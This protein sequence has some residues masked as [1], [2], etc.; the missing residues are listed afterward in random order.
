MNQENKVVKI[1]DVI[2][3]QIPEFIVSENPNFPEF[4][5]QYYI[6]QEFQGGTIDL[7][8]NLVAYRNV[9]AFDNTNLNSDTF[10]IE[11]VSVFDDEIFVDS[12]AG[13][14]KQYGLIKIDDEIIT[15][16][17]IT[18]NSFIGCIRGFSGI[19]SLSQENNQEY[20]TFSTTSA[21]DHTTNSQVFNLSSLFLNEFFKKIKYQFTPGFEE[22]SFDEN[23]NVPNFVSKA[24][25]FYRSK[26][27]D[28]SYKILFKVL[29]NEDVQIVKPY[30]FTFTPSDDKWIVCETFVCEAI[31]GDPTKL[32]GQTLY[33]DENASKKILPASGSIYSISRFN[34]NNKTYYKINIFA[35]YSNN[36]NP[37]GS[38]FGTFAETPRTY[39][40]ENVPVNSTVITVDSTVGFEQSG[41]LVIGDI[42]IEYTDKT[43]TQFL[44][45]T[46]VSSEI[47][48]K[49]EI[50]ASNYVYSYEDGDLQTK[51]LLRIVNVLS[52]ID[53][54]DNLYALKDDPI[55]LE[56]LG[57]VE[58]TPFKD[59][60]IYNLPLTVY[61]G[62]AVT[63]LPS[64]L[65]E[66]FDLST[67]LVKT[68]YS[69]YLKSG[70]YV[71]LYRTIFNEKIKS[72]IAISV[73]GEKT[74]TI[75]PDSP[76][77]GISTY[78]GSKITAK[79][80]LFKS[81]STTFP[82]IND[83][84]LANIQ[85]SYS[86]DSYNYITSNGFPNFNINP[87]KRES[88]LAVN[89]TDYSTLDGDHNFYD[90]DLV[91]IQDYTTVGN[92]SNAIGIN[93]GISLFVKKISDSSIKLSYSA[94]NVGL[95]SYINFLELTNPPVDISISG[96]VTS[97]NLID[98][99]LYDNNLT[100][101]K[102]FKK[103]P[104]V[105]SYPQ[106][107]IET[108]PG[109]IGI[110]CNG[111]EIQN[112]KSYDRIFY[113]RIDS[114]NVLNSGQNYDLN[115]PPR[116]EINSQTGTLNT[117]LSP[118]MTGK[119]N[120]IVVLYS[121]FDYKNTPIVTVSGGGV[122]AEVK[123]EVKMK[124][125]SKEL[126]F[127]ASST[128]GFVDDAEDLFKFS[129]KHGLITGDKII[130]QTLGGKEIG[131]GNVATDVLINDSIYYVINVGAGT[132]FR[133]ASTIE[134]A[135]SNQYITIREFGKGT[136][137]FVSV[138]KKRCI[139]SVTV[140]DT[141]VTFKYK[142]IFASASG[143]NVYDNIITIQNH[144]FLNND[145]IVYSYLG[146]PLSGLI[147]NDIYYYVE[148]V[149]ENKFKLKQSKTSTSTIDISNSI[150]DST[151]FFRYSPIRVEISGSLSTD[152]QNN[153]LGIPA[154]L[155]PIVTG[156]IDSILVAKDE[157]SAVN[158]Y[159]YPSIFNYENSPKIK[160]LVGS[161]ANL[162]PLVVDG[163][164]VKVI[165]KNSGTNYF[166]T[167]ELQ[168]DGTGYGAKL[169]P[170]IVD[171]EI[172][173]V[174]IVNPGV[175][176][177]S[178]AKIKVVPLGKN[179]KISANI[180]S[181]QINEVEK[182]K[183]SNLS[184]GA[185]LG[186]KYSEFGNIFGIFYLSSDLSSLFEIPSL[187]PTQNPTVHSRII[188]W[189]YDGSPI[190]GPDGYR[191]TDGTGGVRRM[192][193]S[194][195]L[196]TILAN[197]RPPSYDAKF[198][199]DDYEYVEGLGDLDEYNGR[200]CITPEFPKGVYAYFCTM[201]KNRTPIFPYFIG[202]NY[203]FVP[204]SSNFD[205]KINQDLD[206]NSLNISKYTLPYGIENKENYYEY[207]EFNQKYPDGEIIVTN[208]SRGRVDSI[209]I[210][211]GGSDY[212]IGSN[213]IFDETDTG[214]SGA[215]AQ[216]LELSGV[217]ISSINSNSQIISNV[218]F[219][220]KDGSVIGICT[221][222]H[223]ITNGDYVNITGISTEKFNSLEGFVQI[224]VPSVSSKL[225]QNVQ[226]QS[227]TGIVTSI[228]IKDPISKFE[229]DS[230]IEIDSETMQVIG[231]DYKNNC[232]NVLREIG[233]SSH[234]P[235]SNVNVLQKNIKIR[236]N[237]VELPDSDEVYY[238]NPSASVS[239]GISTEV[240]VGNT[241]T[242]Y[243]FGY[244]VSQK[245]FLRHG[246]IFLPNHKFVTGD[247]LT[248]IPDSISIEVS[249]VGNLDEIDNLY[250][251][252]LDNDSIGLTSI[253][254]Q[255]NST[256]NLLL[257]T[258]AENSF[259][260]KFKTN[261]SIVTGNI[262][263]NQTVV[264]TAS[265]HGL[266]VGDKVYLNVKSGITTTFAVT[267]DD[268]TAKLK[269]N[270]NNNPLVNVYENDT[271]VFDLSSGT[272]SDTTFK[273]YL[274]KN[275]QIEYFGNKENGLEVTR[276]NNSLTL[277][278]SEYT[279]KIL[280]YNIDTSTK[281]VFSDQ[282]VDRFN[283]ILINSSSYNNTVCKIIDS[284][285]N[286][287]TINY[288]EYPERLSYTSEDSEL[289]YNIVSSNTT[290]PISK[291]KLL[292]K[293]NNYKKL[294]QIKYI[295]G[296]GKN[297]NLLPSSTTIGKI[298][299]HKVVNNEFIL[300]TDRT[301]KPFSNS[302]S[303]VFLS[304]NY[305]V[306]NVEIISRGSN[307]LSSP[308][309]NLYS[310]SSDTLISDF[311]AFVTIKNGSIDEFIISNPGKG[312][313]S[314]D[315]QIIFTENNNG[316]NILDVSYNPTNS[317]VTLTL[318][319]PVLGFT[320]SNPLPFEVGD[321]IFVDNIVYL[322]NGY[323]SKD[324]S[325]KFFDVVG[326]LTAF[327]SQDASQIM[328]EIDVDPGTYIPSSSLAKGAYVVNSKDIPEIKVNLTE[329]IFYSDEPVDGSK[330]I[331]NTNND[332]LTK[333]IKIQ[334]PNT[335]EVNDVIVGDYSRS[336]GTVIKVENYNT[337]LKT[338][339]SVTQEIGWTS[340]QGK[341]STIVQKLPDNDYY[342]RFSYSLKSNQQISNWYS[343]ISDLSH[344]SG[345]KK[346]ADLILE[347]ESVGVSTIKSE[348]SSQINISLQSYGDI[349]TVNDFDLVKENVEDYDLYASDIIAFDSKILTD[350]L[351]SKNNR[352]LSIDDISNL[353][354]TDIPK[355]VTIPIDEVN[356]VTALKYIFFVQSSS[357]FLG[358]FI[359]P[360]FFE[361]SAVRNNSTIY[362]SSYANNGIFN[363][364]NVVASV[365]DNDT[366]IIN[367]VPD[368]PF[369]TFLIRA[370]RE[371]SS[372]T[373]GVT[374][375][376][377]G[378]T[379][380]VAITTSY[381]S[382]V[383]PTEKTIYSIPLT[384]SS[385]GTLFVGISSYSSNIESFYELSFLHNNG[386]IETNLYNLNDISG[387]GTVG[388]STSSGDLII[389]YQGVSGVGVTIHGNFNF[390]VETAAP[391]S[392]ISDSL[393]RLNSSEINFSGSSQVA[394]SSISSEYGA[395]KYVIEVTKTTSG[396]NT[397]KSLIA[398]DSIH[399]K[400]GDYLNHIYY[401]ILG[402]I[403]DLNF[404]TNFDI[405]SNEYILSYIPN[406]SADYSIKFFEKNILSIN[407]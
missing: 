167:I 323:N 101:N 233:A 137:R 53:S 224:S 262:I 33:Q 398:L 325:Y 79:R 130:Y 32:K 46:N 186:K 333:L 95:S 67:G 399:Y 373:I 332:P 183:Q 168:V 209:E 93:T 100:S 59:S 232:I 184:G 289:S 300:P 171:G 57:N 106:I 166:N 178:N 127:N 287:F 221:E 58:K 156:K 241:L 104:K 337:T 250:V 331:G 390:L 139:D 383:T 362:L 254:S 176:Y 103:I 180:D 372:T 318:E 80:K 157:P 394:I 317:Q 269:I 381:A 302:Y 292:S 400:N 382:E 321:K 187:A 199:V 356:G 271:V 366:Y 90:G 124:L 401:S 286:T 30:D 213:I 51:V 29:Y 84:F 290:G 392:T 193:S 194:Y 406:G 380:N 274:D 268:V 296:V 361:L 379:R 386:T 403:N 6:S 10:L 68:K 304:K 173:N 36:L 234:D 86:D 328:Y 303:S 154:T 351:L 306:S 225:L 228:K 227:V 219:V 62:V 236:S 231:L 223:N 350:Y 275:Y 258:S 242:I 110:L 324:Y 396:I 135:I 245:K 149:D 63:S 314:T 335:I 264:S 133:L 310:K 75:N 354:N 206:F 16:T 222:V 391:Q 65:Q 72:N 371:D 212:S 155:K 116:F 109:P 42:T 179:L 60:L 363:M 316:I 21:S 161:D 61:S 177:D 347:S 13:Y 144:G 164:I 330:I 96:Y 260:H 174:S 151:H 197:N 210:L 377:Y 276:Q 405:A 345:Y 309:V 253:R 385:S 131:I 113:G 404:E 217:G 272:L 12:V 397:S 389:T 322:G 119:L 3:N 143:I 47:T 315:D 82:E 368:N 14:P 39:V 78:V 141:D 43:S 265:T 52:G 142:K 34:L 128:A 279:P 326:V 4:L 115:N 44:N 77:T 348:S 365:V 20:L 230:L 283:T 208:T 297:A 136:Q 235:D 40:V 35:G 201:D 353:F 74:F 94:Q 342:Q 352:V 28:E 56:N 215:L 85:N 162:Y 395:S 132:S 263:T 273:L 105:P 367:Y 285:T 190:Y 200:F 123:T 49:S 384:E 340:E 344:V 393:T 375:T 37:K 198:F 387:I 369:S 55:K 19:S 313:L 117:T 270:S 99:T 87:Y 70:D 205:P 121:G 370:I 407:T 237:I 267:Y 388:V 226:Q 229:I 111:V 140:V 181:W 293:G 203:K 18:T 240:G 280:Y 31:S 246:G 196:K 146:T 294:P 66:G 355:Q 308:K 7:A 165:I 295:E 125:A 122:N 305:T 17:G 319:T 343:I 243:P 256:D 73:G 118:Q 15:Y 251:V 25:S 374:T 107:D 378:H 188:G 311:D 301:L 153:T 364:G 91:T 11:E 282:S 288:P 266:S 339:T 134:N 191:F 26:G 346:F 349:N 284:T 277:K 202:K 249:N 45:C 102:L 327:G 312:L 307:Y 211:N 329:N 358:D 97:L 120:E 108:N 41:S 88:T 278:I 24:R 216:V 23:I 83:Q 126:E 150:S 214:G 81:K 160:E 64:Y 145:E 244:G 22:L 54:S 92:F 5:S 98:Y 402:N 163:K 182:L 89:T 112:Y 138:D 148:V 189:S 192:R 298:L 359:F 50:Y 357:S 158:T 9:D 1:S 255:I 69:H 238:F 338:S 360:Q 247:T 147:P 261:R 195:R 248:Y 8:E 259:L 38:I 159:G 2:Q 320:T 334:R 239:I 129:S 291:I 218:N 252:K 175:G 341:L 281:D 170:T 172:T 376:S 336:K 76:G 204:E 27:T 71:D 185:L 257:Y 207:F 299:N 48:N 220:Y 114:I 169:E 152:S